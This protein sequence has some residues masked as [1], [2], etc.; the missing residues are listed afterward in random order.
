MCSGRSRFDFL[1]FWKRRF[2]RLYPAYFIVL[3]LS[4]TLVAAAYWRG[5]ER[6]MINAYP[7][8]KLRWMLFLH[9][10]FVMSGLLFAVMDYIGN[11][12]EKPK[13]H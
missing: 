13:E 2:K 1:E 10:T 12:A 9:L 7:E 11:R 5:I 6:G 3:C 4:M 8:P